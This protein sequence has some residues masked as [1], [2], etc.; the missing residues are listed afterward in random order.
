MAKK[1]YLDSGGLGRVINRFISL[2]NG[3]ADTSHTH[4]KSQITDMPTTLPNP[5]ALTLTMNGTSST[6]TGSGTASNTWYA[7]T[8]YGTAGYELAASG[9]GTAPVWKAQNYATCTTASTTYSKTASITNFKL[10]SGISVKIKFS[11]VHNSASSATLNINSTGA[12]TIYQHRGTTN[13]AINNTN[14][15]SWK[16][17]ETVEF[18]YDGSYWVAVSSDQGSFGNSIILSDDISYEAIE[19]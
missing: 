16:A 5:S 6:Y 9:S 3:K 8:T 18:V 10:V 2:L 12:K 17:G 15:N 4:T 7:P 14:G 13:V 1:K 19:S 11:N